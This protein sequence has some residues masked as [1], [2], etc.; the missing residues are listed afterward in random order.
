MDGG[1]RMS[2][3]PSCDEVKEAY[4]QGM[5][6]AWELAKKL[7]HFE[8]E[9][10]FSD[11]EIQNILIVMSGNVFSMHTPHKKPLQS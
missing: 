7:I 3:G 9:G 5:N 11:K 6:D 10:G 1:E 2:N 4:D 8:H